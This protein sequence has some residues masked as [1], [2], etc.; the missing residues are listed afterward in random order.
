MIFI[1][2]A[3]C[4]ACAVLRAALLASWFA[5]PPALAAAGCAKTPTSPL[6]VNVR[7]KG[8]K[9]DGRTD[10]TA[11]LQAALDKVAGTGGTVLVPDGVYMVDAASERRLKIRNDTTLKLSPGATIKAIP[12]GAQSYALLTVT[13]VIQR[14]GHRRHARR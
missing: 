12:N 8:A 3:K 4:L 14:D 11:A 2:D 1:L 9:G 6:V 13:G 5:P 10:D 7:Q